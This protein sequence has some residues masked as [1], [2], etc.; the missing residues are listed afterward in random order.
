LIFNVLSHK[1]GCS[2]RTIQKHLD[3]VKVKDYEKLSREII[4]ILDTTYRR[5]GGFG[6]M[7]FEDSI[8]G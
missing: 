1:Y 3:K 2:I 4:V 8:T 7:L 5:R 6:V